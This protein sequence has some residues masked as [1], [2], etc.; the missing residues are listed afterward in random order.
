MSLPNEEQ[1]RPIPGF[2][3][4]LASNLGR[5]R[6]IDRPT[7][8]RGRV[9]KQQFTD[10]SADHGYRQVVLTENYEKRTMKVHRLVA[11]AF[12]P[13]PEDLPM[14]RHL[15][16]NPENNH[17]DNLA[18]GTHVDNMADMVGHGNHHSARKT[19]CPAGHPYDAENVQLINGRSRHCKTCKNGRR[20]VNPAPT[21][22]RRA[23]TGAVGFKGVSFHKRTGRYSAQ[24][25][26]GG[27]RSTYLGLFDTPEEAAR[28]YD[29][30]AIERWGDAARLNFG[31]EAA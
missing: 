24:I 27:N 2:S 12:L 26:K 25:A 29:A 1:W 31:R 28:A 7:G 14:V 6:S 17:V 19:H 4:Y 10:W 18:W 11:L 15:D 9:L 20:L 5:V 30:A 13:N 8:H 21:G 16:G 22:Q 23:V 3:Y